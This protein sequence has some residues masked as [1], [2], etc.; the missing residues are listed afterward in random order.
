MDG[1]ELERYENF[2]GQSK[3]YRA[4]AYD[5]E[6]ELRGIRPRLFRANMKIGRLK[7]R[8]EKVEAQNATLR[9]RVKELTLKLKSTPRPAPPPFVKAQVAD[10]RRKRPGRKPGHAAALRPMPAKID[11]RQKVPLPVDA[12]NHVSCPHCNTRLADVEHHQRVLE[13][14]VPSK[15]VTTCYH[16]ASG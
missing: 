10:R 6:Y 1:R 9:Q 15:V 4:R 13:D 2:K 7:E 16:T 5:L 12:Q 14:L 8:L 11:L 3:F